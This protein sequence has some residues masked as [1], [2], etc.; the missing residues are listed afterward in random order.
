[1]SLKITMEPVD[2]KPPYINL[3]KAVK[4][5]DLDSGADISDSVRDIDIR[6]RSDEW[7]TAH[8]GFDVGELDIDGIDT[9]VD[10]DEE[11]IFY[12]NKYNQRQRAVR[13]KKD[14]KE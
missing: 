14:T 9:D 5:I 1:M 12:R 2:N 6:I 4:V 7:V 13:I 8:I 10:V 11:Y 3:G